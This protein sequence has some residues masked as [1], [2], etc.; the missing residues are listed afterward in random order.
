V[1]LPGDPAQEL[2]RSESVELFRRR[3]VAAEPGFA[4]GEGNANDLAE[5]CRR[6]DGL[7]LALE[8]AAARVR[9]MPVAAI[10]ARVDRR[11]GLLSDGPR[12]L[13]ER[14][15]SLRTAVAWSYDLLGLG[16]Q[17]LFR[18][19]SVFR[20]GWTIEAAAAVNGYEAP[21]SDAVIATLSALVD[22]S[23]I[24]RDPSEG[25]EP[26]FTMLETL[27]EFAGERLADAGDAD[28]AHARH[29]NH[30]LTLAEREAPRFTGPD[31]GSALNA[32]ALE[33]DNIR[34]A[35]R[36]LVDHDPT[37]AL[38]LGGAIWRFWQ[39]RG[40]LVEGSRWLA[41]ALQ[42]AGDGAPALTR[43]GALMAAAGLAYWRGDFEETSRHYEAALELWREAGDALG[44][45]DALYGL[46]FVYHPSFSPPPEDAER[47]AR[48]AAMLT[49]AGEL[50]RQALNDAGIAKSGW[51]MG[52][53]MLYRDLDEAR[54]LL[55]DSVQ[56][57]RELDDQ[58]G[59]AWAVRTY[60]QALL[61]TADTAGAAAAF[62]EA[63][64]IFAVAE[65][66]SAMGMLLD[67]CAT[68][69]AA[70]G[71]ELRAARLR[72]AAAGLRHLTEAELNFADDIPWMPKGNQPG[73]LSDAAALE[74]AWAE[75]QRMSQAE[76]IAYARGSDATAEPEGGLRV[77]A[78]GP[79]AVQRSGERL[80]HWGGPK[81]GSRQAQ[82][83]F[84]FL[85]DRG[86]RGVAK[87]EFIE[88][89][90]PDAEMTQ[91]D[92]NFHRTIGGL[93]ST[94]DNANPSGPAGPVIF[95]NG[96]YRLR[97]G[98]VGWVDVA[99]F[100]RHLQHAAQ[101]T[102]ELAAIR[103][104]EDARA[105]YRN[106]YLDDCPVYGDSEYVEE[107]RRSLRGRLL[108]ALVDLGNRYERRGDATLAAARFREALHRAGGEYPA[109][110]VGLERL[111]VAT[112]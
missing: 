88:V 112:G 35:F 49:E 73:G 79:F 83:I 12:D 87:D 45:A 94:L 32:V 30:C 23:L 76:A 99:E 75:G 110:T 92:L 96:R 62:G 67:D 6:L 84:G 46:S 65:D 50:Y 109:A 14:H 69:A 18:H 38:R 103:A 64:A 2:A 37:S 31:A 43:A 101:A 63:L 61:A 102:D 5:L 80:K 86:E 22:S 11:L 100:E 28:L 111:G 81:A 91:G 68:L 98:V 25:P 36:Y 29:A 8:L 77:T 93:R 85:L 60:G 59:L 71:D 52:T 57:F 70:Q 51:A 89:I 19:L 3:A 48:A 4:I 104:L 17:Q 27:R 90:W 24:V 41:N 108:D 9:L 58:F 13:P 21:E 66:G 53:L 95:A 105:L 1:P 54:T 78:L 20:G 44:T 39:M 42:A 56:R 34:A 10:L 15:R 107:R 33:H 16:E 82:A 72:G 26:R 55:G 7:P 74:Q 97:P 40:H 47:T 106:D